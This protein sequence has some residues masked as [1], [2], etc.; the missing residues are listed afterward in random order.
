MVGKIALEDA[1]ISLAALVEA[2]RISVAAGLLET[3]LHQAKTHQDADLVVSLFALLPPS[4]LCQEPSLQQ[5]YALALCR[6]RKPGLLLAYL[7]TLAPP[8]AP[9]LETYRAWAL[10][11]EGRY[12]EAYQRLEAIQDPTLADPGLYWRTRAEVLFRLGREG[13]QEAFRRARGY[14]SGAALGRSLVDEG[15]LL[16]LSGQRSAAR[17]TWAEALAH[18]EEDPYYLAWARHSLGISLLKDRPEEAEQHLLE[19][20]RLSRKA[21]AREFQARALCGLGAVRRSLREWDR[22]LSCYQQATRAACERD[23]QQEA[24]W[25]YA[26][27]LRLLGRVEEAL[28]Y[29]LRALALDLAP[30]VSWLNADIAAAR[31]M[32]GDRAGAQESLSRATRLCERGQIVRA[33]VQAALHQQQGALEEARKLLSTLDP[34][35]L[36]VQEE[37]HCFPQLKGYLSLANAQPQPGHCV[38]VNPYGSLEVRVNGRPVPISPTGKPGE[39]LV[40]LLENGKSASVEHLLDQLYGASRAHL[41]RSRK[42]L[43]ANAE[44]L[45][46]ALGWKNSLRISHGIYQLDP[47]AEWIYRDQPSSCDEEFM[48]GHY[49]NWIQE[50]RGLALWVI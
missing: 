8:L 45:R 37:V 18:L 34:A 15:G 9:G 36:W 42:A 5:L 31:L 11:R 13:W 10:L 35:N 41:S 14:L 40:F 1:Q 25:G 24:W 38:E 30:E 7:D 4:W 2:R 26:H 44:K 47:A 28:A 20:A 21:V 23:D 48:V 29:L 6:S 32:L 43:W 17:V 46:Q 50:R 22:A 19:A 39:L 33:V 16:Y 49:S 3:L 12:E 27:T